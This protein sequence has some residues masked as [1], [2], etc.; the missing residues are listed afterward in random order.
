MARKTAPDILGK[1]V[2][3]RIAN[4]PEDLKYFEKR[5]CFYDLLILSTETKSC[6]TI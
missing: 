4:I 3:L 5:F 6:W 2:S 1:L